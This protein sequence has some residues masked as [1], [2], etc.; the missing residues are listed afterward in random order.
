MHGRST[1]ENCAL[2]GF[3]NS[4]YNFLERLLKGT[5]QTEQ[6]FAHD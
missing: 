6:L 2:V 4:Q 3:M 1:P 5:E